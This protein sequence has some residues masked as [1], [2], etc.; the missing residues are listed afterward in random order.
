[1]GA[2]QL[3]KKEIERL[4]SLKNAE[5]MKIPRQKMP[6]QDPAER[7][8]NFREVP[9]GLPPMT[10]VTEANRCIQ[11]KNRPCVEGCPVR[12]AIPDFIA[13]V[14]RGDFEG[15]IRKMKETNMLPAICGRVCPQEEQCESK[16]TLGKKGQPVAI[17]RLERFV[18]DWERN[19][20]KVEV[21]K[22]GNP[23][24]KRVAVIGSGP[25]GL[26]VAIDLRRYGHDVTIFEALHA[27]GGVLMYG[28]PE[29]RLPKEIV[30]AEVDVVKRM[31]VEIRYNHVIGKVTTV[32]ELLEQYDA[33]F[34][35]TGA[36]L[37]WFMG[38]PGE[39][40]NGVY[41]A[42]EYLTRSNLM[43]AYD[44]P[45]ADTPIAPSKRVAV[46]GGGN[47]AMDAARTALR[48]GAEKV[49]IVYRRSEKEMPA[50]NEEIEH[51]KEEG[52]EFMLLTTPIR[53]HGDENGRVRAAECLRMEL[54]E[55]D[56]SGRRRPVPVEGSNFE[57][58]VDTVIVAIGNG[59]NPLVP[60]T[61]PGL[62]VDPRKGT[63]KT[64]LNTMR[65][66]KKGVFA[67]GDIAIGAATV[68]LAMG[69]GRK[70]AA[71]IHH[72]L[73]TGQWEIEELPEDYRFI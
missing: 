37:P 8:H 27:P 11:C 25:A 20:G 38:I 67:G 73:T 23:T 19:E 12:I 32:D 49:F 52:V 57:V 35:G 6:E 66:S 34:L 22:V 69:H 41:S 43:R 39:N 70:A 55:P 10:A 60:K 33:V 48:L 61:T 42:N 71:S 45:N 26:T 46:I 56:A 47:V 64:N 9:Y 17:G 72:Y 3:D 68:I 51:A 53:Y 50:R 4:T 24:G 36:G 5:R 21:P 18:A 1:M 62:E 14:A 7:R 31:G 15:G 28:I 40:L 13:C 59:P 65:T 58:E 54:G 16:C 30:K 63:I 2:E 44:F 29:F